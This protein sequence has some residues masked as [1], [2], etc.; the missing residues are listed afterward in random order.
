MRGVWWVVALVLWLSASAGLVRSAP[1][2][3]APGRIAFVRGG[4]L[5]RVWEDK[6][7][8]VADMPPRPPF[9]S[10][11]P[12]GYADREPAW[13]PSGQYLAL[14]RSLARVPQPMQVPAAEQAIWVMPA[15]TGGGW[16]VPGSDG[17]IGPRW[18]RDGSL[19]WAVPPGDHSAA[20]L[21]WK[22]AGDKGQARAVIR[23][24][25]LKSEYYGQ[26]PWREVFDWWTPPQPGTAIFV[27][28]ELHGG[29]RR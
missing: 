19:L 4:S 7:V 14:S 11:T 8:R 12:R 24:I 27:D 6:Q 28:S 17:G 21:W 2:V 10:L 26:W 18:G 3:T 13:Q 22:P 15:A 9:P 16:Q 29:I 25:D 23:G 20:S 1:P 5:W